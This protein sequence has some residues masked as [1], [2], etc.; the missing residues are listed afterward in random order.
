MV[1]IAMKIWD[2][3]VLEME[4]FTRLRLMKYIPFPVQRLWY[5]SQLSLLP[6]LLHLLIAQLCCQHFMLYSVKK[7]LNLYVCQKVKPLN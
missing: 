4:N 7:H 1:A 2:I 6:M 3:V 5:L